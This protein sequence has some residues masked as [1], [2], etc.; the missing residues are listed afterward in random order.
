MSFAISD[1]TNTVAIGRDTTIVYAG[2]LKAYMRPSSQINPMALDQIKVVI[3][4]TVSLEE[5]G[6]KRPYLLK[7]F[8]TVIYHENVIEMAF[9]FVII[10]VTRLKTSAIPSLA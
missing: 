2:Y 6:R 7:N 9:L 3:L 5:L 1:F 10:M 8:A 4:P